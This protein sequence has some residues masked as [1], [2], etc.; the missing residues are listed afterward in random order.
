MVKRFA[1]PALL[2]GIIAT[3][4]IAEFLPA[5]PAGAGD[6]STGESDAVAHVAS[7]QS[8][9]ARAVSAAR[10][11]KA[12]LS[13]SQRA[14]V[15]Y[16]FTASQKSH[17]SILPT[18]LRARNGVAIKDLSAS[19]RARLRTLLRTILSSQGY[20]NEVAVRKADTYLK[21]RPQENGNAG[22]QLF[23]YGEGLYYVALF[24]T[25]SRSNK[26]TVQFDGHHYTLNMTFG[27]ESVSNTP[28][29]IGVN[30]PTAF[31]MNGKTYQPMANEVAALF[32][33][34]RSLNASQRAAAR[35]SRS[36][37]DVL[38][39]EGNDGRFPPKQGITVSTLSVAQQK[40]VTRAIRSYVRVMPRAQANRR[41]ATYEK[42][43]S[44]TKL[45]WSGSTDATTPG[46]YVRIHGPRVWIEIVMQEGRVVRSHYHSIE[47]DVKQDY[48]AGR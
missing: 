23:D 22:T 25:P 16:S 17:W 10:A 48:G 24:G 45:A 15:Q 35:L 21:Q 46:A 40:L 28:Y 7:R 47:R 37:D 14:A 6:A 41:I 13:S 19:Q 5:R 33:A 36:F 39:G 30:P 20:A 11:F 3:G 12:S 2:V 44:K 26:W 9:M 4:V 42:Q 27:G 34:V 1:L 8:M 43:Y 38:V 29:F 32:G 31:K 18:N